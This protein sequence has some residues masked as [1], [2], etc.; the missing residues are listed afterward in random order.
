MKFLQNHK[1]KISLLLSVIMAFAASESMS[2]FSV[3]GVNYI[4]GA[5]VA[6]IVFF[7]SLTFID[8]PYGPLMARKNLERIG[9]INRVGEAPI[10]L[11]CRSD[12]NVENG[13]I[14]LFENRNIPREKWEDKKADIEAAYN[15][16]I[17]KIKSG[18]NRRLVVIYA[19][20]ANRGLPDTI[21]WSPS[22]LS[23]SDFVLTLGK[24]LSGLI[25]VNLASVP[26]ILLGGST[27]SGKSILLKSL[28]MQC[29]E[30]G[31]SVYIA[32]FKGGID[33]PGI[34]SKTCHMILDEKTLCD[35][36]KELIGELETRKSVLRQAECA[37]I[38]EYNATV[39]PIY[40]RIVIA[41]D[42]VAE[43]LDKTGQSKANKE[44]ID[45]IISY[46]STIAR[47]GRA[48]GIHLILATQRPDANIIP[49]QIKNNMDCRICGRADNI[50]SQ[51]ILDNGDA[52][53]VIPKDAQG[54]FLMG[55]GT[56]FQGFLFEE[57]TW[58]LQDGF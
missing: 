39:K 19:I 38:H 3:L 34:W 24:G 43:L 50:L 2:F 9:L 54:R 51:I 11:W 41:C 53:D 48:M 18:R 23:T 4:F 30:K 44:S 26:H 46:L 29:V 33:F 49:G 12:P 1:Y 55:D 31:A 5:A 45:M 8:G 57:S 20:P 40:S 37:N 36:L 21:S 47:Q 6:G 56:V 7:V 28:L 25:R 42:E 52:N 58:R 15:I 32:D 27:G 22:F 13:L 14:F 35:T 17:N 10:L 16:Y